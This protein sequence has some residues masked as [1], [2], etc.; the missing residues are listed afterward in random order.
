VRTSSVRAFSQ[1][2]NHKHSE[3]TNETNLVQET[4][5]IYFCIIALVF[6]AITCAPFIIPSRRKP[7]PW[8]F[9]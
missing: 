8:D 2:P 1:S 6:T 3:F 5:V 7:M 4:A 9:R